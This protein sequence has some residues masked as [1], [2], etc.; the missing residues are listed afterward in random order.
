MFN[1]SAN[2]A[3]G[4]ASAYISIPAGF[5][6]GQYTI[7]AEY[8][9]ST[10]LHYVDSSDAAHHLTVLPA[11]ADLALAG[12]EIPAALQPVEP[13]RI[14]LAATV[15]NAGPDTANNVYVFFYSTS[16]P[17]GARQTIWTG[18]IPV[19]AVG[20]SV[21]VSTETSLPS[22]QT[23][24]AASIS[25][26]GLYDPDS[27]N[28]QATL[29]VNS[30]SSL[31]FVVTR[32]GYSFENSGS[33]SDWALYQETFPDYIPDYDWLNVNYYMAWAWFPLYQSWPARGNCFGMAATSL[34]YFSGMDS[35]TRAPTV[36]QYKMDAAYSIDDPVWRHIVKYSGYQLGMPV[37]Q[38]YLDHSWDATNALHELQT[39]MASHADPMIL[40]LLDPQTHVGHAVVPF[41][42]IETSAQ[43]AIFVYDSDYQDWPGGAVTV[44]LVDGSWSYRWYKGGKTSPDELGGLL[45]VPVSLTEASPIP[46]F[47]SN[48]YGVFING[49]GSHGYIASANLHMGFENGALVEDIPGAKL[50]RPF[51]D[52]SVNAV[53]PESY[54][55]PVGDYV[56]TLIGIDAGS[57]GVSIFHPDGLL[58]FASPS[59]TAGTRDTI[60]FSRD[61]HTA[62]LGT[63]V[64]SEHYSA[65]LYNQLTDSG[66]KYSVSNTTMASGETITLAV[67]NDGSGFQ[68]T[69]Q[70]GAKSYDLTLE[71]VGAGAGKTMVAG[72]TLGANESHLVSVGDWNSLNTTPVILV[73]KN[74]QGTVVPP[75]M[76]VTFTPAMIWPANGKMINVTANITV[77]DDVD[78]HPTIHLVS[79]TAN[80]T[81][82]PGDVT[83]ATIGSDDRQFA[84]R[85]TRS[86]NQ[87]EGRIYTITYSATDA[88]RRTFTGSGTVTVP[89]DQG[90]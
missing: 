45:T 14:A 63:N 52:G 38:R 36:N 13:N 3:S 74:P 4:V 51:V 69:N 64:P 43:A 81:L 26:Y 87:K 23:L 46:F 19:I 61:N 71:Q 79:I 68:I 65:M 31:P 33:G 59:M 41:R 72:L 62:V 9:D 89:H 88:G 39:Q 35:V 6:P 44:S 10:G 42:V 12:L 21:T 58:E 53:V 30:T 8:S 78:S 75:S 1:A 85:A 17:N 55:L 34:R 83:G 73:V 29:T 82:Q 67:V 20:Q 70:G 16:P 90:N 54:I 66:R 24:L 49:L 84:L 37:L 80:E 56:T 7:L 60:A 50:L 40:V 11:A 28:N 48:V 18:F 77:N 57:A 27:T 22:S 5:Y 86:G 76:K 25:T 32:D 15:T 47:R 2:V